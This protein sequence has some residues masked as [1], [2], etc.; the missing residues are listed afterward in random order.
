MVSRQFG[1]ADEA[2]FADWRSSN[3]CGEGGSHSE[4]TDQRQGTWDVAK[5]MDFWG[6]S[7]FWRIIDVWVGW[8]R[9]K[10]RHNKTIERGSSG[11]FLM[12]ATFRRLT[13]SKRL[14]RWE[15]FDCILFSRRVWEVS[16]LLLYGARPDDEWSLEKRNRF[17]VGIYRRTVI[18]CCCCFWQ[19]TRQNEQFTILTFEMLIVDYNIVLCCWR[20]RL[21]LYRI[22][23]QTSAFSKRNSHFHGAV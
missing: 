6:P 9:A 22:Y 3:Y 1:Y 5:S 14:S 11:S 19:T 15:I 4:F 13:V 17:F 2:N 16:S 23:S 10:L 7:V 12:F 8:R 20:I 21:W 18:A